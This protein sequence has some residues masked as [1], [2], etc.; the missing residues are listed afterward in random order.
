MRVC[1]SLPHGEDGIEEEDPLLCPITQIRLG[2]SYTNIRG[3][4]F[5]NISQGWLWFGSFGS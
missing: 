5:K 1:F 3:E 2:A 4:F